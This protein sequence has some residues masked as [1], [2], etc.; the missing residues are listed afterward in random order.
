[1]SDPGQQLA[2]ELIVEIKRRMFDE[3]QARVIRCVERL[4]DEQVW[5]RPNE[6][7][8]SVG[9]LVLHLCGNIRQWVLSGIADEPDHRTRDAEF[10]ERGPIPTAD[11]I[12]RFNDTLN[13]AALVIDMLDTSNPATLTVPRVVQ[14]YDESVLSILIHVTEHLS[15]HTGQIAYITKML[16]DTDLGFYRGHNL[17]ATD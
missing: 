7:C 6:H 2:A 10:A 3:S 1:M 5:L 13:A 9:N 17:N 15:Y 4:T 11:L 12:K 8:N 14:G 16:A